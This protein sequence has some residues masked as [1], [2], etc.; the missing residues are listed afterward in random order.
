MVIFGLLPVLLPSKNPEDP[1]SHGDLDELT[2]SNTT[3]H[4]MA[5][6]QMLARQRTISDSSFTEWG[7]F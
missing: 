5:V 3:S 7:G 2:V 6:S 1:L 4:L